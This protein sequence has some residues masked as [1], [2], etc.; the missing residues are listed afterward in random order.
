MT[1]FMLGPFQSRFRLPLL[2]LLLSTAAVLAMLAFVCRD[3]PLPPSP[4]KGTAQ[5]DRPVFGG[6]IRVAI[7]SDIMSTNPGVL[8]DGNTD[9]VLYHV[10]EALVGYRD[11]LTVGPLLA[12]RIDVEDGGKRYI[13]TLRKGLIFHNGA[14]VTATEV[15]WS[16]DRMLRP[17]TGFRCREFY[18]GSGA[19]GLKLESVD[20][21]SAD[22]VAFRLNKP[23][24][25]FLDRMANLQCQ[26]VILHPASVAS[27]GTWRTPIGT[28]PYR[29]GEW[30]KGRS[31]TLHR[32][33]GY[34]PRS[35]PASGVTGRKIAY[36][37]TLTFVITPDRIAAKSSVY[38]G[39]IDLLFALPLSAYREV[40]ARARNRGDIRVY[41]QQTLDWTVM[42]IQTRDP[43]L[44]D[45]RLR[46]AIAYAIAP[47]MVTVFATS[48]LGAV[49]PSATQ[50][51]SR[52]HGATQDRWYPY[53]PEKA[54]R[55]AREA[56]Y[57]GQVIT[58]QANRKFSYMYDAAVAIQAMLAAA[59]F[60]AKIEMYDWATQ[61][62][63]FSTGNFQLS[64]FGYSSRSHPSLLYGNFV[65]SKADRASVQWDDPTARALVERLE[66]ASSDPEVQELLDELHMEMM[67]QV[68]IIGL[69][70][71]L[72]VDIADSRLEGY[73]PWG[74][75]RP[76]LWGVWVKPQ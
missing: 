57:A 53:D 4:D 62:H 25:L 24:V 41:R 8:R 23:S 73:K 47:D 44:S 55:L 31:V 72:V 37:D 59:G 76:R 34:M 15:K 20:V 14:P 48:G 50:H 27:D 52:F 42:L 58:I 49:N 21:L 9:M 29:L 35:D 45:V 12:D 54:R 61:L 38:A 5:P 36:A 51:L 33:S 22:R 30:R 70:N 67:R 43:L 75:G 17:E 18:D 39:D 66:T 68:P 32:F 63:N 74:F 10:T 11:D 7:N 56:G 13:F 26:T 40:Q 1:H 46:R 60:N 2:L 64:A 16:W 28:G 3:A 71:D 19:G 69:Y 65:G 6:E